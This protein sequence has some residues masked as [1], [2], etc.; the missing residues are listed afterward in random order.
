MNTQVDE[1][2]ATDAEAEGAS[3][4]PASAAPRA[5]PPTR[6]RGG[7]VDATAT[8]NA[9]AAQR[10]DS[11]RPAAALQDHAS[12]GTG[13]AH[14]DPLWAAADEDGSGG[15]SLAQMRERAAQRF[16]LP[17]DSASGPGT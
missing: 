6:P 9:N 11:A 7:A 8:A 5:P 17:A 15:T 4:L 14:A 16:A 13:V 10:T 1:A 3:T 2:L 12:N